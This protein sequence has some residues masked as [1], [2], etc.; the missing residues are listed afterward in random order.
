ML[1]VLIAAFAAVGGWPVVAQPATDVAR[2]WRDR[3]PFRLRRHPLVLLATETP[4]DPVETDPTPTFLRPRERP[5]WM[6]VG[7]GNRPPEPPVV[8]PAASVQWWERV[9][10][11]VILSA[12]VLV[13]GLLLAGLIGAIVA[14]AG[15]LLE[16]T[17]T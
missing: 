13:L 4:S 7:L 16:Q 11:L 1:V 12:L 2:S 5:W 17:A 9:R 14:I 10:S 8:G 3:S 15:Y 6:Q